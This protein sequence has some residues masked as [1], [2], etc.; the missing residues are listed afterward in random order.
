[1]SPTNQPRQLS[2]QSK[3]NLALL[4]VF[5]VIMAVSLAFSV[6]AERKLVLEVVEQQTRDAA[7]SY[8]DSINTM[9]L[10]GTMAQRGVLREK[11]L[12][13]PGV[14]DARIIRNEAITSVFGPGY[15]HQAPA[16]ELDRRAL[17]DE[18]IIE[19][20]S[21]SGQRILTVIN[22][23]HASRNYRG[24]DCLM[25]HMVPE[26]SVVGAVR[27]SYSLEE[28]DK[29]VQRNFW[30]SAL[31]Q[32]VLL[33]LGLAVIIA[34]VRRVVIGRVHALRRTM[35]DMTR[36]D[37]LS[38]TVSIGANDEIGAMGHAFNQMITKFRHSLQAVADVTGRLGRVTD[39]VSSVADNTLQQ[40]M[41]QRT[42]TDMVASAM[43][44]MS[45]TVQEVAGNAARTAQASQ[46]ADDEARQGVSVA[47]EASQAIGLLI[48]EIEQ[49][50]QVVGRVQADS[51]SISEVLGVITGIAEQTNLLALNAAIEAARAGEQGRGFAVVADEVRTLASRTQNSTEEIQQMIQRLHAAVA[52]AVK[53]MEVAR[54]RAAHSVGHVENAAQSLNSIAA[55]VSGIND[56]NL[57]IAAAAEEQSAVAEEINRNIATISQIAD[58]TSQ[59]AAGTHEQSEALVELALELR[60]LV[61]QFRL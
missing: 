61:S 27:I 19:I 9:M 17:Q 2:V 15:D 25:C 4:A 26:D 22:P 47:S 24:T 5:F 33:V 42:E 45:A 7:D 40:V 50:A 52:D 10:T 36:D 60:R 14:V 3:I 21:S 39:E 48:E 8:F 34:I 12:E 11:I 59:G 53:A 32:A 49:A 13:R 54:Q 23:V 56:M 28:L 18:A 37:D 44:E 38:H 16:D 46:N 6:M 29:Q 43:N 31:I 30:T 51:S 41:Q 55:E 57:Q 58:N 20:D 1:M 35:E